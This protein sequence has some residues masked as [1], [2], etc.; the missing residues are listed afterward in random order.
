MTYFVAL[1]K[2][3]F[4]INDDIKLDILLHFEVY[5]NIKKS[6]QIYQIHVVIRTL[7]NQKKSHA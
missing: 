6:S 4:N 2:I 5:Y 3:L 1:K 7:K